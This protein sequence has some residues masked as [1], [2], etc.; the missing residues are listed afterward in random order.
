V[1][2]L[3]MIYFSPSTWETLSEDERE[4]VFSGHAEFTQHLA[5]TGEMVGTVAL[6]DPSQSSTVRVRGG[7][8]AVT[9]GPF[10]EA[11]EYLAG[12]YLV[13][14]SSMERAQELAAMIPDARFSALEVRPLLDTGN[15]VA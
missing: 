9:D 15:P 14:C 11:K 3:I 6:A 5:A 12:Y 1:K 8:P 10:V 4:A 13:D 7:V 2:Y